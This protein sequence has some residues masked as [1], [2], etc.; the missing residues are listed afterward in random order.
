[1]DN[2]ATEPQTRTWWSSTW[3]SLMRGT[4]VDSNCR[5]QSLPFPLFSST[6]TWKAMELFG[7][8]WITRLSIF[9]CSLW[10]RQPSSFLF[11][12][13]T[14]ICGNGNWIRMKSHNLYTLPLHFLYKRWLLI[15]LP[16]PVIWQWPRRK[17]I[18]AETKRWV[19]GP[20]SQM[21]KPH[22][23]V[24]RYI[25]PASNI[26]PPIKEMIFWCHEWTFLYFIY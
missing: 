4:W 24:P 23:V 7:S 26:I 16:W 25:G 15:P 14:I 11:G 8:S 18:P 19:T 22:T 12:Y 1:M 3:M 6:K 9:P 20:T 5:N 2:C 10:E 13:V 17:Q 21:S